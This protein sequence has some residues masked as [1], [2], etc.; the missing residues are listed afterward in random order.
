MSEH[1]RSERTY[2]KEMYDAYMLA[3][4]REMSSLYRAREREITEEAF[5]R[6]GQYTQ[7]HQMLDHMA[8]AAFDYAVE[9][10]QPEH[11]F[12][13]GILNDAMNVCENI[14]RALSPN[15]ED[16]PFLVWR[17]VDPMT[18]TKHEDFPEIDREDLYRATDRYLRLPIRVPMVDRI[19]TDALIACE[20]V[21]YRR[22][23]FLQPKY[24]YMQPESPLLQSH[25]LKPYLIGMASNF[26]LFGGAAAA[27]V[28]SGYQGWVGGAW[29]IWIGLALVAIWLILVG[30]QTFALPFAWRHQTASRRKV[31][32]LMQLMMNTYAELGAEGPASANRVHDVASEAAKV[33]V[34]WP[35]A[36]FAILDDV[37]LRTARL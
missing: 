21:A 11:D 13:G 30:I 7:Y 35:P 14:H 37:K 9:R 28:F 12:A 6:K 3:I 20:V 19:L 5:A 10:K 26:V 29:A 8:R 22:L 1:A 2:N 27:V 17:H 32:D 36:L 16:A 15:P 31:L 24:S 34:V 33:G 4:D 23:M 18:M 25:V